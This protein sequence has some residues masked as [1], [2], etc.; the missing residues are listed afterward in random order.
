MSGKTRVLHCV[1][2]IMFM[3]LFLFSVA[4]RGD[5]EL[6][7]QKKTD[8][9]NQCTEWP[10]AINLIKL[11]HRPVRKTFTFFSVQ[12]TGVTIVNDG[13]FFSARIISISI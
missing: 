2:E 12:S 6:K 13:R 10:N 8:E 3:L 1:C 5:S 11:R 4:R 7:Q 9:S